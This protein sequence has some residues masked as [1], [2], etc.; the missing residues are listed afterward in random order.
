M[1][2]FSKTKSQALV[3]ITGPME[4]YI[5]VTDLVE[6]NMEMGKLCHQ[7]EIGKGFGIMESL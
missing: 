7:K 4:K 2:N 3:H 6:N 1:E 5:R